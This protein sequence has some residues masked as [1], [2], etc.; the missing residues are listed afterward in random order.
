[1]LQYL[2]ILLLFTELLWY[3]PEDNIPQTFTFIKCVYGCQK[4]RSSDIEPILKNVNLFCIVR[5][6][7]RVMILKYLVFIIEDERN[8]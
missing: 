2:F 4:D 3:L 8:C 1:M 6:Q 7:S 5:N